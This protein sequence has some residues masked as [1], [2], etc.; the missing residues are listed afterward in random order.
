[1]FSIFSLFS[2][3][4]FFNFSR[5]IDFFNSSLS[6]SDLEIRQF[7]DV[8]SF[9]RNLEHCQKLYRYRKTKLFEYMFWI[10]NDFAWKW[11]KKQTHFNFLFRFEMTL[12]KTFSSQKQREL[13]TIV[14]KRTKRKVRKIA[15]R[16]ELKIIKTTKQTSTFQNINIFDSTTCDE[17]EFELYS[18]IAIF[19]QYFEQ[20]QHLYRKSD[21]LNLLSK[22]LCD[23]AS[24][25]FKIQS[26]FISLKRFNRILSKAFSVIFL[27]RF[28]SRR[29]NFQSNTFEIISKSIENTSVQRIVCVR[30]CKFCK[31]NFNCNEKLY[32]HIRNHE[33]LKLVTN[34][35]FSIK[36]INLVC[37]IEKKLFVS[38][39]SH[40][41]F[42]R[43]QKSIFES[44]I[45]SETII[46][47][48]RSIFQFFA[49]EIASK[50]TKKLSTL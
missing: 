21:L 5:D 22:C 37:E 40:E 13:K 1:M 35:Y 45:T 50:S 9:L 28:L 6:C 8:T 18:E 36:T 43:F 17:S 33:I 39:K 47:L 34:F 15:K 25:W 7:N 11:F 12:I 23:F 4:D 14:Q 30:T 27:K 49:L 41:S 29:S 38:Q 2:N 20:C 42:T 24:E 16:V 19:L 46:L 3:F 32:E 10:F 48:K 44:A 31:Q 26:K